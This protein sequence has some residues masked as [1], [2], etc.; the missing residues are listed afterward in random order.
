MGPFHGDSI[1][2]QGLKYGVL[3]GALLGARGRQ[4]GPSHGGHCLGARGRNVVSF[5]G[6]I[7][8]GQ[9]PHVGSF[10][11]EIIGGQGPKCWTLSCSIG[12]RGPN[13]HRMRH[14]SEKNLPGGG[15]PDPLMGPD[16]PSHSLHPHCYAAWVWRIAPDVSLRHLLLQMCHL[17]CKLR[18]TL[19]LR[20]IVHQLP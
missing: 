15:P 6:G 12:G 9:G 4:M 1:G 13:D 20:L 17:L 18:T 14:I 5:H 10:N 3:M 8:G 11:G 7:I 19:K 16:I 2:G